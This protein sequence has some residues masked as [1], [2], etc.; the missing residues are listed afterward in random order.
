MALAQAICDYVASPRVSSFRACNIE[1]GRPCASE[2]GAA[3]GVSPAVN[4]KA[5]AGVR[6]AHR[7]T[8]SLRIRRAHGGRGVLATCLP[9]SL[10]TSVV[11]FHCRTPSDGMPARDEW[12][13]ECSTPGWNLWISVWSRSARR[14]VVTP[15]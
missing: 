6:S 9:T 3:T 2:A 1:F 11:R 12:I 8:R 4:E 15:W 14:V 10:A 7:A 13:K 5:E